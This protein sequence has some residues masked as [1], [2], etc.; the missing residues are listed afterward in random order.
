MNK[1]KEENNNIQV[2]R[3]ILVAAFSF[4]VAVIIAVVM[5]RFYDP[6]QNNLRALASVCMD[7]VCII[8][9]LILSCSFAFDIIELKRTSRLYLAMLISTIIAIFLDFLNWAFDGSLEFGHMTFWFTLGS[10]CMG[11]VLA[12]VFSLYLYC[13]MD[14]IHGISKMRINAIVCAS[15]NMVSF[16]LTFILAITGTAFKFVDGHYEIGALYDIVT[17]IPILTLFYQT[18]YVFCCIKRIGVHDVF[19]VA[20]YIFFMV[21]GAI[22]EALYSIGTTYVAVAIADIFIFIML[23]NELIATEKQNV[24]KWMKKSTTDELTGFL[25]RHAFEND[26]SDIEEQEIADDFV[27]VSVDV[28]SLKSV[29][30][31]LGHSAGDELIK[32][33]AKCLED[34]FS[35]YGKLYRTG[36][37]EF[38]ALLNMDEEMLKESMLEIENLTAAWKGN[39][40]QN[41]TISLGYVTG[42]EADDMSVRDIAKLA[43]R[44]MYDAKADYYR[45]TGIERRRR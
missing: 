25:N 18:I 2:I 12:C 33:A 17:V 39:L 10:L 43:D 16:V 28:N 19:A 11:S 44:R 31:S 27:Y 36:G 6:N 45:R 9:L 40:V 24:Q 37:D 34:C 38:I 8:I 7:I 23:Q 4:F 21:S 3:R 30:D 29:N 32:G 13:Y 20:G 5:F 15:L 42:K 1:I 35:S 41:L 14:E 26:L 22:I